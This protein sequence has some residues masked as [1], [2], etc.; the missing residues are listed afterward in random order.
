MNCIFPVTRSIV[1]SIAERTGCSRRQS[2]S[3]ERGP[4]APGR[5]SPPVGFRLLSLSPSLRCG[6]RKFQGFLT[7]AEG[8]AMCS[9]GQGTA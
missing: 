2:V 8:C 3:S 9:N 1:S 4:V 5:A 6:L 7:F